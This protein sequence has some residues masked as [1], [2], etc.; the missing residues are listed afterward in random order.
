LGMS[1]V[2][3]IYIITFQWIFSMVMRLAPVSGWAGWPDRLRFIF[4]P[5]LIGI[6]A[7]LGG[8]IRYYRTIMLEE[9]GKEYVRTARAKGLHEIDILFRH[10]L[11][12]AMIPVLTNTVMAIPFLFMGALLTETFFGIPGLG[13]FAI[14][15]FFSND[16]PS[17]KAVIFIGAVLYQA[18]LILTDISYAA[19][20]PRIVFE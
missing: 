11:K 19:V 10:A 14:D 15:A 16:L 12:N 2:I 7:G 6:T 1:V 3:I 4:I 18:G 8:S 5:V 20:D 17:I 13:S 9:T